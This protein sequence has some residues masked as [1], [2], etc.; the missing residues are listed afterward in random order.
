MSREFATELVPERS[1][2]ICVLLA[3]A[4]ATF[5]GAAFILTIPVAI[6]LRAA[7]L[8][9]W[10]AY[11]RRD[12]RRQLRGYARISRLWL[13]TAG[14]FRATGPMGQAEILQL[15]SGSVVLSRVAWLWLRFSDGS[16]YGELLLGHSLA[17]ERWH[18]LQLIW[19]QRSGAFG[20]TR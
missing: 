10:I 16:V 18:R 14:E 9:V 3:A 4:L 19:Q 2:R 5:T 1:T 13:D 17:C 15:G 6:G 11:C 7:L 20:R 8:A 12:L